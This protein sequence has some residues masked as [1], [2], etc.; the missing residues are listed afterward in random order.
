MEDVAD[1]LRKQLENQFLTGGVV[2]VLFTALLA[3]L[4]HLPSRLWG[5]IE[6]K[7]ITTVD[8]ADHDQAFF[9]I[10]K[11]LGEH[12]YTKSARLLTASTRTMP[13]NSSPEAKNPEDSRKRQLTEVVFSPAPGMHLLRF[14]NHYLLLTRNRK[15][16]E[17]GSFG[18]VAYHETFTFQTFSKDVVRDLIF[19]A[20]E[21]AF[22]PED[23]RIA[24]FRPNWSA[25]IIVQRRLPRPLESVVLDG[26]IV[27][28][29]MD[30][31]RW[32]FSASKWYAD[33]GIPYQ[34]GY[35]LS[36]PPGTGK[37]SLVAALA[38]AFNRDIYILNLNVVDDGSLVSLMA[39]LPEHAIIL[40]ED[41]DSAFHARDKTADTNDK[42]TFSG[43]INAID[44]VSAPP[45][46]LL[47]MTTNYIEKID[48]AILRPGRADRIINF[49]NATPEMAKRIFMRFFPDAEGLS[50]K[51]SDAYALGPSRSMSKVQEHLT[52][53]R[54]DP[55]A[56]LLK[57]IQ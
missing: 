38:S 44:G 33:L 56:A 12:E 45:G 49:H 17:S 47:F 15:E 2:L 22:P 32:F 54:E 10:Q 4:R 36:G 13:L 43:F 19:E 41:L 55:E 6:R 53:Y 46:R 39:A 26:V 25:W 40:I 37:T 8:V 51:F 14:H 34:R 11:W 35:M 16:S 18:Q 29:L 21:A 3:L 42:I 50:Q 57:P 23:N 7:I 9:W 24:I 48:E 52:K 30:E 20:R 5:F 1:L 31:L 27:E 28:E